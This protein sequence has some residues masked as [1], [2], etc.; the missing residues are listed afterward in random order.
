VK[1]N[2]KVCILNR[3]K[4]FFLFFFTPLPAG[5]VTALF[6][7]ASMREQL[8]MNETKSRSVMTGVSCNISPRMKSLPQFN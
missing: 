7:G 6:S 4:V 5:N 1:E 2:Y 3:Q 8:K